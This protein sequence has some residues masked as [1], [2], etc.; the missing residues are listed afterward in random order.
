MPD[1]QDLYNI[2]GFEPAASQDNVHHMLMYSC[3]SPGMESRDESQVM[4]IPFFG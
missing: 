1:D 4:F 2:V 3:E